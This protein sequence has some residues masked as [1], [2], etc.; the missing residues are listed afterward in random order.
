MVMQFVN[1]VETYL[2]DSIFENVGTIIS[3]NVGAEST[4]RLSREFRKEFE[5]V[6]FMT[7][8]PFHFYIRLAIDVKASKAFSARSLPKDSQAA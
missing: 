7:L 3:F 2:R 4:S 6:E 5:P 8:P 1:Q